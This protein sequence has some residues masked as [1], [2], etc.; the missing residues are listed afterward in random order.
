MPES[1][2]NRAEA[3]G[4]PD[5]GAI[6]AIA[7]G[8]AAAETETSHV[9]SCGACRAALEEL[10]AQARTHARLRAA[11]APSPGAPGGEDLPE[12]LIPGYRLLA[13]INRGSQ[14]VVYRAVQER[15]KR[16]VAVKMLLGGA[17]ATDRQRA[18]FEREVEIVAGLNHSGIVTIYDRTP[19]RGG[20]YAY[21]M[22]YI[23][24]S[25]PLDAWRPAS[26]GGARAQVR[27]R[28]I[29]FAEI[30]DAVSYAHQRGVIHRDLKPA[31]ILIDGAGKPHVL[32]F[33]IAKAAGT[34]P[35][36]GTLTVE[37]AG[38]L[39]YASP[40][41]IAG[42][43][44]DI[45]IRTDVYSL[46]VI[47]FQMLS[48]RLPHPLDGGS[49]A[50]A[51]RIVTQQD[52]PRLGEID[53]SWRGDLDTIAAKAL[54]R[55]IGRRY[56]SA[57]AL[58]ADIRRHLT[59][60]TIEARRDSTWYVLRKMTGRHK[61]F[62]GTALAVV[63][64]VLAFGAAMATLAASRD[65]ERR[66]LAAKLA[67]SNIE[68]GRRL[69][70]GGAVPDGEE[71]IWPELIK[72]GCTTI[73][74]AGL[75]FTAPPEVLHPLWALWQ[76]Q[77]QQPC[78]LTASTTGNAPGCLSFAGHDARISLL[79]RDRLDPEYFVETWDL[80]TGD[81]LARAHL[82]SPRRDPQY[83]YSA[84]EHDVA[85]GIGG[86]HLLLARL[87]TGAV[88]ADAE[89]DSVIGQGAISHDGARLAV[90]DDQGRLRL[91]E[92]PSLHPLGTVA[93][94]VPPYAAPRFGDDDST[95]TAID[96]SLMVRTWHVDGE[97]VPGGVTAAE[98]ARLRPIGGDPLREKFLM[99]LCSG[100]PVLVVARMGD[101]LLW[102]GAGWPN[103]RRL[104]GQG[105][106]SSLSLSSDGRRLVTMDPSRRRT[107][108]WN[109][110]SG[111]VVATFTPGAGT[112]AG[113]S[114]VSSDGALVASV[115]QGRLLKVWEVEPEAWARDRVDWGLT[116]HSLQFLRDSLRVVACGQ[117]GAVSLVGGIG[118]SIRR[119][120]L[121]LRKHVA[122]CVDVSPDGG[123]IAS[124][125]EDGVL[126]LTNAATGAPVWSSAVTFMRDL[127][128]VR[129][130]R[131]GAQLVV[132]GSI[133]GM[134]IFDAASG[135]EVG[136]LAGGHSSRISAVAFSPDGRTLASASND[137]T[138]ILWDFEARSP[139]LTLK[140]H[141]SP[142]RTVSFTPGGGR[143]VTGG[144][145]GLI[146]IWDAATG[147]LALPPLNCGMPVYALAV[148]PAGRV[149][150][151]G[152]TDGSVKFWDLRTGR[153]LASFN[154]HSAAV[155][156]LDFSPDGKYLASGSED[157]SIRIW[158][159]GY[160]TR[161]LRNNLAYWVGKL[162]AGKD[163]DSDEPKAP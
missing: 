146:C 36:S 11:L 53:R 110:E 149:A 31:N 38:T 92:L 15:T 93:T 90:I 83:W 24:G 135:H 152:Q 121:E 139:R 98:V 134:A 122:K 136:L 77:A 154:Y 100:A 3:G 82:Q 114:A 12:D 16:T 32:D 125:A 128:F 67:E 130:T 157:G 62:V 10:R 115:S 4:C 64:A 116:V 123:T 148:H 111:E 113:G 7:S 6:E 65:R 20:R 42:R 26:E 13:E 143:L 75:L 102:T 86:H 25:V 44:G 95:L 84:P 150:A 66:A 162:A 158:D 140:K 120:E 106:T 144:D 73:E 76:L 87:S 61:V 124:V 97:P 163:A 132:A 45:D 72:A 68:L 103:A 21:A 105:N 33:G 35:P 137:Q 29:L 18:R 30:C 99:E 46:G 51:A 85:V 59:G 94:G 49:I 160:Y 63:F 127:S 69:G 74:R 56:Q 5:I 129:F 14:G 118:T 2:P 156:C 17:F 60:R 39:A 22:E 54:E 40:E 80:A 9:R 47:L 23:E 41:Q 28:L 1:T 131:D 119:T 27:T 71:R 70:L 8:R 48:G 147:E 57:A 37:F 91:W 108:V 117:S 133:G 89:F 88:I 101:V 55:D 34:E 145:D 107:R 96:Q 138:C 109:T 142:I 112:M 161:H 19:V 141:T 50:E 151:S 159:L 78:V 52:A 58:A 126:C 104:E 153:E 79:S 81:R 155:F 43:S